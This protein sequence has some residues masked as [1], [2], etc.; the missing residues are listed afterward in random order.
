MVP[1]VTFFGRFSAALRG[2]E[3]PFFLVWASFDARLWWRGRLLLRSRLIF[4]LAACGSFV[5][6]FRWVLV[7]DAS[8]CWRRS[9][10]PG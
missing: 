1:I 7:P 5:A 9:G 4:D 2:F 10:T 6:I 3:A 8:F